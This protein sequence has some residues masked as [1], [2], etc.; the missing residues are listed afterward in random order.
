MHEVGGEQGPCSTFKELIWCPR[1]PFPLYRGG[2]KQHIDLGRAAQNKGGRHNMGPA[3][4]PD[5]LTVAGAW[6]PFSPSVAWE[7]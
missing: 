1:V 7:K 2:R 4:H 3:A 6:W 5:L